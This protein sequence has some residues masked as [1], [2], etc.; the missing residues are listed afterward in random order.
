MSRDYMK[1]PVYMSEHRKV[2]LVLAR[3]YL[4]AALILLR[5]KECRSVALNLYI[6]ARDYIDAANRFYPKDLCR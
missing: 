3:D 4:H 2:Y 1:D 5:T 6:K